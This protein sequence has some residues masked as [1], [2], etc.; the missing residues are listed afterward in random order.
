MN[1][2]TSTRHMNQRDSSQSKFVE[3][4]CRTCLYNQDLNDN[5]CEHHHFKVTNTMRCAYWELNHSF[6]MKGEEE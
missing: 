3:S 1:S 2:F 6:E 5:M 4:S